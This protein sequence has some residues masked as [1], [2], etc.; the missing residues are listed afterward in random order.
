MAIPT[1]VFL[2]LSKQVSQTSGAGLLQLQS[3]DLRELVSFPSLIAL[4]FCHLCLAGP[5]Y[6]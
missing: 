4:V 6:F 3:L 5:V 1:I 2:S